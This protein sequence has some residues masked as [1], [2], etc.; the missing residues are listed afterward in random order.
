MMANKLFVGGLPY[1]TTEDQLR[2]LFEAIG[3]VDSVQ[4]IMDRELNRSKGFGFVTMVTDDDAT[5]AVQALDGKDFE[6]RRLSVNEARPQERRPRS[7]DNNSRGG[8]RGD[9]GGDR[10]GGGSRRY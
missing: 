6:G 3:G 8:D 2:E 1:S 5:A 4:I 9:R 10:D 7:F